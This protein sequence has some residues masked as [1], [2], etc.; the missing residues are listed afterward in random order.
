MVVR[1]VRSFSLQVSE[2]AFKLPT[3]HSH[4]LQTVNA[5]TGHGLEDAISWLLA[6]EA[7]R[8]ELALTSEELSIIQRAWSSVANES[9]LLPITQVPAFLE[10]LLKCPAPQDQ[11]DALKGTLGASDEVNFDSFMQH[12]MQMWYEEGTG[13]GYNPP[14]VR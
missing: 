4:K 5:I 10:A 6:D 11:I 13:A 8:G 7:A 3:G 14:S 12:G 9:G 1:S 2:G